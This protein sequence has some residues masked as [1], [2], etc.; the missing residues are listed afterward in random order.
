M[1]NKCTILSVVFFLLIFSY[2]YAALPDWSINT[3]DYEFSM[4][5]TSIVIIDNQEARD[6]AD[7]VSAWVGDEI[8][9]VIK[10]FYLASLDRYYFLLLVYGNDTDEEIIFKF[11]D[12]SQDSI[13]TLTNT[14]TF[15]PEESEG[16]F[17]TPYE[18]EKDQL[19]NT[20]N[21]SEIT[22]ED[23]VYQD[24]IEVTIFPNPCQS[25]VT[26]DTEETVQ[27]LFLMSIQGELITV[28]DGNSLD[29]SSYPQGSY[30]IKILTETGVA[31][32]LL[33]KQ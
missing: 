23:I 33:M 14:A 5:Y 10:P 17:S 21:N 32:R 28:V 24:S 12:K 26:I 6:T 18:F 22:E 31:T 15:Y 11:Y 9:G 16:T 2:S 4:S 20:E 1:K 27:Q 13:Y 19:T 7:R 8:R 30:L 29:L 3:N 25:E